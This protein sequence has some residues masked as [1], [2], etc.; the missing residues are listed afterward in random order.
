MRLPFTAAE[1]YFTY[2]PRGAG[3][4]VASG[5]VIARNAAR[6]Q[7]RHP[8]THLI[9][10]KSATETAAATYVS[11]RAYSQVYKRIMNVSGNQMQAYYERH[12]PV[13]S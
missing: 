2:A 8:L 13:G 4:V 12:L 11:Y 5:N 9:V 3:L 10:K 7:A 6:I 1:S